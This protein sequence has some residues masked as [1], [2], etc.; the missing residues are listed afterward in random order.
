MVETIVVNGTTI[1]PFIIIQGKSH[2]S[3][4]YS[5]KL[6][7]DAIVVLSDSRYTNKDIALIYLDHLIKHMGAGI[8]K[9]PKVLLMDRHGSHMHEDFTLKAIAANIHPYPYPGHLTHVLQPLDVGVFQPYKHW[10]K[11]A[12]QHAMRNLDIDYNVASFLHDLGDIREATF[13][14]GTIIGA[15]KK[16]GS[17][18]IN[19]NLALE[20]MKKYSPPEPPE[21]LELPRLLTTPKKFSQTEQGLQYWQ[22]YF[23]HKVSSPHHEQY[24]SWNNGTEKL[25][26]YGDLLDL[27]LKALS[28]R[29]SNQQKAKTHSHQVLQ[30]FGVMTTEEAN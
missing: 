26:A 25:L 3:N 11:K 13:K 24:Q 29:I 14:K 28:T 20:K 10:H 2:I 1:P 30:K 18:P 4:W 27:Q 5:E 17:W 16:S 19:C 12:V 9:P 15:F 7:K 8:D 21:E 22:D 6:E 23:K